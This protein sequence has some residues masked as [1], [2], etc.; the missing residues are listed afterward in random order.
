MLFSLFVN[1]GPEVSNGVRYACLPF[2]ARCKRIFHYSLID[3]SI[4]WSCFDK[5]Y[6]LKVYFG[7]FEELAFPRLQSCLL[8]LKLDPF[9]S[10]VRL[11]YAWGILTKLSMNPPIVYAFRALFWSGNGLALSP[12]VAQIYC[13]HDWLVRQLKQQTCSRKNKSWLDI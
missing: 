11:K 10:E 13:S 12:C 5:A 9:T 6:D 2:P 7:G 3:V 8:T 4:S 1:L